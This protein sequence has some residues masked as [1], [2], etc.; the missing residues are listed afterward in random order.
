MTQLSA[1]G[2]SLIKRFE[3]LRLTSYVDCVGVLTIGYGHTGPDVISNQRITEDEAEDLLLKDLVRFE[4]CVKSKVK[5]HLNQNEYDALVSFTYNVGCGAFEGSTLLRLLNEGADKIRIADEFGRWVKGGDKTIPGLVR[6]R[7]QEKKLFL[8]KPDKHPLLGH[9][10]LSK[11]DTWL[12]RKPID[13]S[14]LTAE[15]KLFIP[16][17]SAWEWDKISMYP[18]QVHKEVILSKQPD[19]SWWIYP[20]HWKIINDTNVIEEKKETKQKEIKLEVPYYN[21]LDNYRDSQRTCF[22]SSCA[23][24]LSSQIPGAITGDDEYVQEVFEIGDTT[25]SSVQVQ[26]LDRFGLKTEFITDGDWDQ[27]FK[28]LEKGIPVPIGILHKG[29]VSKPTGGGHWICCV[30]VTA[31]RTKLWVHDPYGDLDLVSGTYGSTDGEYL[32]YSIKNLGPR[33]LVEGPNSGWM[34]RAC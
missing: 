16:K 26:V 7:E 34:I 5:V 12:K 8:T 15:E 1:Q 24:L 23:M 2:I 33:W 30:G 4:K 28:L 14:L 32:Q 22:S 27:V 9:S 25:S 19:K 18:G 20:D 29:P 31:D 10:I 11:H 13:S 3:G 17:N 6:R 21:Q